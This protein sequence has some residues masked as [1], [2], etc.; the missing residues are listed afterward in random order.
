MFKNTLIKS[1]RPLVE[2]NIAGTANKFCFAIRT[3]TFSLLLNFE[4]KCHI[5]LSKIRSHEDFREVRP[6]ESQVIQLPQEKTDEKQIGCR[7]VSIPAT[8]YLL[9]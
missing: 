4:L 6:T 1:T 2:R 7:V 3:K 9:V 8:E 5:I